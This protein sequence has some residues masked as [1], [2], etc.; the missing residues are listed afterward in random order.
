MILAGDVGGTKTNLGLF[1][2]TPDGLSLAASATFASA[3]FAGLAPVVQTFL[4][5]VPARLGYAAE[6]SAACFGVAGPVVANRS[7]TPNLAWTIDGAAVAAEVG[8][9]AAR[10][11]NDLVATALGIPL[12]RADELVTLQSGE[13]GPDAGAAHADAARGNQV[14]IAAGTGLG[15][16]LL[17]LVEGRRVTVPSEGGHADFSPR[18]EGEAALM[19]YLRRR[20]GE[21]VSVER[22]VSGPGL[23]AVYEHLRDAGYA[24]ESPAVA[25]ALAAGD[26]SRTIS[27][28]ALSG[29]D[30]LCSRAVDMFVAAY[31][32]AAGNLALIC[33]ASGGVYIGGGIAPKILPRLQ[34]GPFL[35]AFFDKGRM[36]DYLRR[37]PIRVILNDRTAMLGAAQ[38]AA[39]MAAGGAVQCAAGLSGSVPNSAAGREVGRPA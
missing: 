28:A 23:H 6:V 13:P 1:A 30:A 18:D 10:L 3:E 25:A 32:A 7:M 21:H 20:F 34:D 35:R 31:G 19:L 12:L 17:P 26:P 29:G 38:C 15:M 11:I 2:E 9:P 4:R 22:V 33:T 36:E 24:A 16:A 8:L 39:E 14:L 37:V 5:Q 27:E